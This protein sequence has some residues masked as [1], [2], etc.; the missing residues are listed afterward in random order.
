L[1]HRTIVSTESLALQAQLLGK[2]LPDVAEAV[3][4]VFDGVELRF[5]VLKGWS[6]HGC[7]RA[8]IGALEDET[9]RPFEA[10]SE[11][12][13]S[14]LAAKA[15]AAI[16]SP[17]GKL[18]SWVLDETVNAGTADRSDYTGDVSEWGQVSVSPSECAKRDC[19]LY[20]YCPAVNARQN[21]SEAH[22]VVTNHAMLSVQAATGVSVVLSNRSVGPVDHLVIDEAHALPPAV[23]NAGAKTLSGRAV[24]RVARLIGARF[25]SV[26]SVRVPEVDAVVDDGYALAG[27][28]DKTVSEW[29]RG[30]GPVRHRDDGR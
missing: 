16:G 4:R 24:S 2:D 8:A 10:D 7:P 1:G 5:A 6:N 26:G 22:I 3:A 13:T 25:G 9:G 17:V 18:V 28:V 12:K 14:K 29:L 11:S 19:P 30:Q 27:L 20:D 21:V 23:R 15:A